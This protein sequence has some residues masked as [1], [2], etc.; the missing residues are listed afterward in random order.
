MN[1][2]K[3]LITGVDNRTVDVARVL[4]VVGVIAFLGLTGFQ[5]Y[6]TGAFDMVNYAMAYSGL[7]AG[8]A[9]G[10]KIKASTEPRPDEG[11]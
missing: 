9:A 8:G 7:L 4:W 5:V 6:K 1:F 2:I 3:Q 11:K 10:V